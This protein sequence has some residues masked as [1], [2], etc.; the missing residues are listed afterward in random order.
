MTAHGC[1]EELAV[2]TQQAWESVSE[3][4]KYQM[5]GLIAAVKTENCV[6]INHKQLQIADSRLW[7]PGHDGHLSF[8]EGGQRIMQ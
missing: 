8:C 2:N 4:K 6:I 5:V 3:V 1:V 7:S